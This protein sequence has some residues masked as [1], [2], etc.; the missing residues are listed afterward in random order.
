MPDPSQ[1]HVGIN[2]RKQ[3]NDPSNFEDEKFGLHLSF[4]RAPNTCLRR[5]LLLCVCV[6]ELDRRPAG[7]AKFGRLRREHMYWPAEF[8]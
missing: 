6:F 1:V 4:H 7:E 3:L 5:L 8:L 2:E